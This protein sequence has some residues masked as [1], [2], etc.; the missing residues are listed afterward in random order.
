MIG[1]GRSYDRVAGRYAAELSGELDA[2]PLDRALLGAFAE[3]TGGGVVAD[4]GCG[5]GHVAAALQRAGA[6]VVATDLSPGMCAQARPRVPVCASDMTALPYRSAALSGIAC[7][8][9]VIHLDAPGRARAYREFSRVLRPGGHALIS[10]HTG[11][12]ETAPGGSRT[13]SEWWGEKVALT[14]HFLDPEGE[15]AALADAGLELAARLDRAPH[16]GAEHPSRRCYLLVR[17]SAGSTATPSS[18]A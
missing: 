14:F 15:I 3:L 10:F 12:S 18:S 16:P 2:K 6:R 9:A 5:P 8:Y 13:L 1:V 7:L 17:A 11:D 4:V